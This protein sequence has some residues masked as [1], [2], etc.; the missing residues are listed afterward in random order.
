LD[1]W[2]VELVFTGIWSGASWE[3]PKFFKVVIIH[4]EHCGLWGEY[5]TCEQARRGMRQALEECW[6]RAQKDVRG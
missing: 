1:D 4:P 6:R 2:Q 3:K 5:E